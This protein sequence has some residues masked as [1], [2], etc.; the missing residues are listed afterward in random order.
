[1]YNSIGSVYLTVWRI[2]YW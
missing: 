1:M 2:S